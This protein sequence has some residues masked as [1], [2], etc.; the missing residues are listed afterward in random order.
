MTRIINEVGLRGLSDLVYFHRRPFTQVRSFVCSGDR[1]SP[2]VA[3][4]PV[5]HPSSPI[6]RHTYMPSFAGLGLAPTATP[7]LSSRAPAVRRRPALQALT[8]AS[9]PRRARTVAMAAPATHTDKSAEQLAPTPTLGASALSQVQAASELF[10]PYS[11]RELK[12]TPT[13]GGVNNI[14]YYVETP[15]GEKFVLRVYNNGAGGGSLGGEVPGTG[16]VLC[17]RRD[18]VAETALVSHH[19]SLAEGDD[20]AARDRGR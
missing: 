20:D 1:R 12:Y 11:A 5:I 19:L 17:G 15:K 2:T 9:Q 16:F 6:R 3:L 4:W 13:T 7:R 18:K 14:V 8:A 10:L